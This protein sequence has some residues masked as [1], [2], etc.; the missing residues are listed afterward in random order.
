MDARSALLRKNVLASFLIK[1]WSALVVFLLA[2]V[3][4]LCLGQ[5]TNGVWMTLSTML[6]WIETLDI[7][8]GNGLRN[9]LAEYIAKDDAENARIATSTTFFSLIL[10]ILP[11]A[12]LLTL[13]IL[14]ADM[15]SLLNIDSNRVDDLTEALVASTILFC[16]TFVFKFIGNV[17]MALQL[18]AINN[19]IIAIGQTLTLVL[20]YVAYY[21]GC[22]SL[23]VIALINTASPL[24]VWIVSYP[25]TFGIRYPNLMPSMK[26]FRKTM[27]RGLY[28][29]GI[30]FFII[31]ISSVV[32]F[33]STNLMIS[34][35]FTPE[36]VTPYNL[37]Y[38]Y[39]SIILVLFTVVCMPFWSATTDAYQRGDIKWI[40]D[41]DKR[42]TRI[43]CIFFLLVTLML[44]VSQPVYYIWINH[45]QQR[46]VEIPFM[47]SMLVAI[48]I[49]VIVV[50]MRYSYFLNG[51]GEL[52]IQV[53]TTCSAAV[54]FPI[55]AWVAVSIFDNVMSIIAVML[56][57]NLPG[58]FIN[59]WQF[60]RI[61]NKQ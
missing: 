27:V 53:Y 43:M 45:W 7:G 10:I 8:L 40:K 19:A 32:L 16:G 2:P 25:I 48:Y 14:N 56:L 1:G 29:L 55:L 28:S 5:Y 60:Q 20:T 15:N 34:R 23:L 31:Q 35:W 18:P 57:V 36:L 13:F 3:T 38:R 9:K 17:Y 4:L 33:M 52:K 11:V 12:F 22:N 21:L 58:L 41:A 49:F 59:R 46:E 50:S 26:Y 61:L 37:A 44:I 47:M 51:V 24:L 39:F 54:A 42:M 6:V 30:Q